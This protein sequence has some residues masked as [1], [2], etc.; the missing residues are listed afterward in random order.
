MLELSSIYLFIATSFILCLV[1]GPDNIYVLTQG[2]TKSKKAAFVTTLGLTSGITIHTTAAAF[3]IS[4]IFQ[5]SEIAFNLVKFAGAA[6]LLYIAYQAFKY[7]NVPLDLSIQNSSNELKKLYIKGFI[8]NVLN[9]KVSIFFLAFLPQFVTPS[10]G[11]IPMQMIT[12]GVIF[13]TLT[14]ITFSL[15]GVTGNILSK[16]LLEKPSIVKYMNI[17]TSFV[18]GGLAVKLALSSK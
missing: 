16:K 9:P 7:R 2:M 18:L 4:V 10:N 6:Y 12:L 5:T 13:M 15:I 8:M 11:N 17:L 1:P 3:G 14:I